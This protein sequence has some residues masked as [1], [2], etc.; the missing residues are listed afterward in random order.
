MDRQAALLQLAQQLNAATAAAD[1]PAV[2]ACYSLLHSVLP[3]LAAQAPWTPGELAAL[4][5]LRELHQATVAKVD[6]ATAELGQHLQQLQDNR[7]GWLAYALDS[8]IDTTGL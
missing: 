1:W 7:E 5:A 2:A 4:A 6:L 8:E 3:Q